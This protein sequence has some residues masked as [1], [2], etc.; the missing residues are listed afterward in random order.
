MGFESLP[1]TSLT[2]PPS[3]GA[4]HDRGLVGVQVPCEPMTLSSFCGVT[5]GVSEVSDRGDAP[6]LRGLDGL[7]GATGAAG[8]PK[9]AGEAGESRADPE[10]GDDSV[11]GLPVVSLAG[12]VWCAV[13]RCAAVP[14]VLGVSGLSV[15]CDWCV[16]VSGVSPG[17]GGGGA[18]CHGCAHCDADDGVEDA[19]GCPTFSCVAVRCVRSMPVECHAGLSAIT[20]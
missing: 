10:A 7:S 2:W 14:W 1:S 9:G 6:V 15:C 11:S 20:R 5:G 19:H 18:S 8:E 4:P 13:L 12:V 16:P 17:R 3:Y